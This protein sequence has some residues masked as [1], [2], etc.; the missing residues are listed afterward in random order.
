MKKKTLGQGWGG[1]ERR[2]EKKWQVFFKLR[3][4]KSEVNT[5]YWENNKVSGGVKNKLNCVWTNDTRSEV[6]RMLIW[7]FELRRRWREGE[8]LTYRI[9]V[10]YALFFEKWNGNVTAPSGRVTRTTEKYLNVRIRT[11]RWTERTWCW[12]RWRRWKKGTRRWRFR[13]WSGWNIGS[14]IGSW[15]EHFSSQLYFACKLLGSGSLK[16]E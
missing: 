2:K 8:R 4:W 11:R 13:K 6:N 12:N 16:M 5:V 14:R 1:R 7:S 9:K 10:T 3:I 15:H